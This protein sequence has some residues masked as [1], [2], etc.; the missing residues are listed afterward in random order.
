MTTRLNPPDLRKHKNYDLF[1]SEI[2]LWKVVTDLAKTKQGAVVALNLPDASEHE[3]DIRTKVFEKLELK[4]LS[5]EDGL[6]TLMKFL[7]KEL[8]KDDLTDYLNK[9]DEFE[10]FKRTSKH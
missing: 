1:K 8:G 3:S 2:E 9:F 10:N 4:D 5:K 7:D 6:D